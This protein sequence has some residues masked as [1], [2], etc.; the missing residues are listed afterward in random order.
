MG[1]TTVTGLM[2]SGTWATDW[3]DARPR[4]PAATG[5]GLLFE[6]LVVVVVAVVGVLVVGID[7][8]EV[9]QSLA[10]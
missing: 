2:G 10:E 4:T 5:R 1:R 8:P 3:A 9:L 7:E 6:V